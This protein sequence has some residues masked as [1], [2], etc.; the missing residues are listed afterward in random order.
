M[1]GYK[2]PFIDLAR[3]YDTLR[4][5][6]LDQMDSVY[7]S[8]HMIDGPVTRAFENAIAD[9]CQRK[10]AVT[11]NSGTQALCL[12]MMTMENARRNGV[13]IPAVSFIAT[14]NSVEILNKDF[15][16]VDV[17]DQGLLDIRNI[18]IS[19]MKEKIGILMYVN[20]YGNMV[21]QDKL[22]VYTNFFSDGLLTIEIGRAHV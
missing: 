7:L 9:R 10:H 20:L 6:L 15:H 12:S 17:N 21:D 5:E 8:G 14:K 13:M 2:I 4:E 16:V 3:Q 19:P 1:N 11:I 18:D 22:S